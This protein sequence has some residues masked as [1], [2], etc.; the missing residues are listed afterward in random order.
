M[1]KRG[2]KAAPMACIEC[3]KPTAPAAINVTMWTDSGLVVI[4]NVPA[5][6]CSACE[7]QFY[8]ENTGAKILE[9]ANKGFPREKMVREISVPVYSIDDKS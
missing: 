4:E 5:F 9:L 6:I 1:S 7:E 3:G 8:D 2:N